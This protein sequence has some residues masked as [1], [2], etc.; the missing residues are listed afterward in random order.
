MSRRSGIVLALAVGLAATAALPTTAAADTVTP[1]SREEASARPVLHLG[2]TGP[3]VRRVNEALAV[4]PAGARFRRATGRAV[5]AFRTSVGL[6]SHPVVSVRTWMALGSRVPVP[7]VPEQPD[8]GYGDTSDWVRAAQVALGVQPATG[9]FGTVTRAAVARFQQDHG[10]PVTGRLD[11]ATW[12][13]LGDRVTTPPVDVT[14][15]EQA[16]T[17][18]AHRAALGVT[19]FAASATARRVVERESGGR[20]DIVSSGGTYRGKWQMNAD[21]WRAYGGSEFA[22]TPDLAT[23]DEQDVVAYRGWVDRWW[24]PWPTA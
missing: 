6:S 8:L 17:S 10:L 7:P 3:W 14:T 2:D 9:Y 15:T 13:A 1:L 16:R 21:F 4:H 11:A 20:C 18:R 5:A 19:A 24:Q 12:A 22:A 23:C